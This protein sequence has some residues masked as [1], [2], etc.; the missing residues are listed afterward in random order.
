MKPVTADLLRELVAEARLA[1]SVHN[2]QPT[3]WRLGP[4]NS[5]QLI[6]DTTVRAPIADPSGHDIQVS[7]GAA[8]EGMSLAL[9]R[10][11]LSI[12]NLTAGKEKLSQQ[13][14]ALCNL[15][16]GEAGGKDPLGESV[17]QRMSWRGSFVA[18]ADDDD[19][20]GRIMQARDDVVC[21]RD[22]S[23]IVEIAAW[24]DEADLSFLRN[25]GYRRELVAWMRLS[26]SDSR[27]RHDG[28]NR[29]ALAIGAVESLGAALVLGSLFAPLDRLGLA[30]ALI[31]DRH[32]TASAAGLVLF[33]RPR[34]ED[35]LLTG[36]HFYRV[37]LEIDRVGFAACPISALADHTDINSRLCKLAAFDRDGHRLVNVFRVGRPGTSHR[38]IRHFRLPVDSLIV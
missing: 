21:V 15:T 3:R 37:W 28:L 2:I 25:P 11:G 8:L 34:D 7:H 22:R 6:D 14:V 4:G 32:K 16:L 31:S 36:R 13:H 18:R 20:F 24:G 5:L 17:S 38:P 29:E 10:R 26:P 19:G 12:A 27:Y 33:F 30:R 23:Q 1:P 35:P 9:N